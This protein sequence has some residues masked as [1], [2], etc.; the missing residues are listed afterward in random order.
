M[1]PNIAVVG[2]GYWGTNLVRAFRNLKVLHSICDNRDATNT[3]VGTELEGIQF[4]TDYSEVLANP[5]IDAVVISTPAA[6]HFKMASRALEADKD[7]FVEKPLCTD[8]GDGEQ[9]AS[10]ARSRERI[11]MVGHNLR[12]H[13]AI[14]ELKRL[15]QSGELGQIQYLYSNRLNI[16]KIRIEENI[17]W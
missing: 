1:R 7:V 6:T 2:M 13:P 3:A 9:L 17:L 16:G 5:E 11:L 10:L 12:Y 8:L 14:L 4:Y 15:I